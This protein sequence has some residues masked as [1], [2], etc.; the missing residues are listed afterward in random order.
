MPS[1]FLSQLDPETIHRFYGALLASGGILLAGVLILVVVRRVLRVLGNMEPV[2]SKDVNSLALGG[3]VAKFV[4]RADSATLPRGR[5][6]LW[7][8]LGVLWLLDGLLQ[9]QPAMSSSMFVDMV[10]AANLQGQPSWYLHFLG[11]FIQFWTNHQIVMAVVAVYVQLTIAALLILGRNRRMGR[12]GLWLSILWGCGVWVFGEGMGGILTGSPTWISG[13][14]GAVLF[15]IAGAILLLVPDKL[16]Y[17]GRVAR[18]ASKGMSFFWLMA[19]IAQAWPGSGFWGPHGLF[20]VFQ[21]AAAM[22]QSG[23]IAAPIVAV[24]TSVQAHPAL[25]NTAF[26]AIMLTLSIGVYFEIGTRLVIGLSVIWLFFTWWMGQDFGVIGG[27][28]TDPNASPVFA[29]LM[30]ASWIWGR[31]GDP[32]SEVSASRLVKIKRFQSAIGRTPTMQGIKLWAGT[33]IV[34]VVMIVFGLDLQTAPVVSVQAHRAAPRSSDRL[35]STHHP[36]RWI[37]YQSRTH[38][39]DVF[40]AATTTSSG[41]LDFNGYADGFLKIVV[42][43][44]WIVHVKFINEQQLLKNSAMIVPLSSVQSGNGSFAPAFPHAFTPNPTIG[45]GYGGQQQFTFRATKSGR[46]AIVS[47]V[48]DGQAQS[49]MWDLFV[50]SATARVP[51]ISVK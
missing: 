15:Y 45:V 3:T 34:A 7:W 8:G 42:P 29:L 4:D 26:V 11:N 12:L 37:S 9:V 41:S 5:D 31:P 50:V 27:V 44:N 40:L 22:P 32:N 30:F 28:G 17:S 33:G 51:S 2:G 38:E 21:E 13:S 43:Q 6:A 16:W 10:F 23:L 19:A 25:W 18:V 1:G 48:P 49:S 14:P 35:F 20:G 36:S 47:A 24:A 39:A 46:Y